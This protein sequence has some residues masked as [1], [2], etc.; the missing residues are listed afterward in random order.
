MAHVLNEKVMALKCCQHRKTALFRCGL[1]TVKNPCCIP[2]IALI[3]HL[4]GGK[5]GSGIL[6]LKNITMCDIG[7][8]QIQVHALS[9][10]ILKSPAAF[11]TNLFLNIVNPQLPPICPYIFYMGAERHIQNTLEYILKN[12]LFHQHYLYQAW[13][14]YLFLTACHTSFWGEICYFLELCRMKNSYKWD[15]R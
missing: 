3:F 4:R 2:W 1:E 11:Y 10:T 6:Y 15:M 12:A 7:G 5:V 13:S 14:R 8:W 9:N